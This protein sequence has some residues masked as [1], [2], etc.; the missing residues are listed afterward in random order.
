MS[1]GPLIRSL[2][3]RPWTLLHC[4]GKVQRN[5]KTETKKRNRCN[6]ESGAS[7]SRCEAAV[8][9]RNRTPAGTCWSTVLRSATP[10]EIIMWTSTHSERKYSA[11]ASAWLAT[12]KREVWAQLKE[13]TGFLVEDDAAARGREGNKMCEGSCKG[14]AVRCRFGNSAACNEISFKCRKATCRCSHEPCTENSWQKW[15]KPWVWEAVCSPSSGWRRQNLEA[16]APSKWHGARLKSKSTSALRK[17]SESAAR[18]R[19]ANKDAVSAGT[20]GTSASS[21]EFHLSTLLS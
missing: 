18:Q 12:R 20:G 13:T 7:S 1:I 21:V 6:Q 17:D 9:R 8:W 15:Y 2:P 3:H 10:M 5:S 11:Q 4:P 14:F 16:S 19:R